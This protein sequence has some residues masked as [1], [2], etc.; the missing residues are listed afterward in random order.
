MLIDITWGIVHKLSV[1]EVIGTK[2]IILNVIF[3]FDAHENA[4]LTEYFSKGVL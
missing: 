1:F 2:Y 4:G 3:G